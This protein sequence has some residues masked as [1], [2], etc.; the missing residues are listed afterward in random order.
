MSRR[1]QVWVLLVGTLLSLAT[2]VVAFVWPRSIETTLSFVLGLLG[3]LITLTLDHRLKI[4]ELED[5]ADRGVEWLR[6]ENQIRKLAADRDQRL[7]ERYDELLREVSELAQGTYRVHTLSKVYLDDIRSIRMLDRDE[8]LLSTCPISVESI[9][10]VLT[11]ISDPHYKASMAA[12]ADAA[13]RGV[14]VT[15]LYLFKA[16]TL[17][18]NARVLGH[19]QE[20]DTKGIDVRVLLRDEVTFDGEFDYVI[21]GNRKVSVGAIDPDTGLVTGVHVHTENRLVE[22]YKER[23]REMLSVSRSLDQVVNAEGRAEV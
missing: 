22:S 17:A 16:R 5:S 13:S 12:H 15:R 7:S 9:D 2:G 21:F 23:Y 3:V 18:T 10:A 6:T 11:Q 20:L 1:G 14:K 4:G 19:L 8:V